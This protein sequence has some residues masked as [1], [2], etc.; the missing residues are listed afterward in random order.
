M[1][2]IAPPFLLGQPSC[3]PIPV[4]V[5][6]KLNLSTLF[7]YPIEPLQPR[8]ITAK[9]SFNQSRMNS[10]SIDDFNIHERLGRGR[11][12][13]V[14]R[15]R[16]KNSSN[17]SDYA[18]KVMFKKELVE[19]NILGQIMK[20]V[21]IHSKIRHKY[22]LRLRHVTQDLKRIYLITDLAIHGNLFTFLRR[23]SK[24][25]E[26]VAGK[27]LKQLLNALTYLHQH[28]IVHRDIKCENLLLNEMG[29]L[30]LSD[31]GWST[32]VDDEGRTTICG[33]PD[34]FPPEMIR[35]EP[36]TETVDSWTCGI[37]CYELIAG[38]T[39]FAGMVSVLTK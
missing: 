39:P 33:T 14:F 7:G 36:Y 8:K 22:I 24:F 15:V 38:H 11:F 32:T 37:L 21:E 35:R 20:E 34:Y 29:N 5:I 13:H 16:L 1:E 28:R 19:N 25:P 9:I 17:T 23:L 26:H 30:L 18:L 27:Y 6:L 2:I 3:L 10:V 4:T 12:G 31:F